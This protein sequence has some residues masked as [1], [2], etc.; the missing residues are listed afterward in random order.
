MHVDDD[1]DDDDEIL[2][3]CTAEDFV[4]RTLKFLRVGKIGYH[5]Q[6]RLLLPILPPS[7]YLPLLLRLDPSTLCQGLSLEA[8]EYRHGCDLH[9]LCTSPFFLLCVPYKFYS[10][11]SVHQVIN[12]SF[13]NN[14]LKSVQHRVNHDRILGKALA[15]IGDVLPVLATVVEVAECTTVVVVLAVTVQTLITTINLETVL[16]KINFSS[17]NSSRRGSSLDNQT[18]RNNSG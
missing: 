5:I 14:Q 3:H 7:S 10:K 4:H 11:L 13:I 16:N 15:T 2:T 12:C 18:T 8:I 1:D 6:L 17:N 9:H